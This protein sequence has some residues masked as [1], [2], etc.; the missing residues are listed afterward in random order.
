[1]FK[2]ATKQ[3]T[4]FNTHTS[5]AYS[6]SGWPLAACLSIGLRTFPPPAHL[7]LHALAI[8]ISE[9]VAVPGAEPAAA[10]TE[11]ERRRSSS[12][13]RPTGR[14]VA[15]RGLTVVSGC[16][17]PIGVVVLVSFSLSLISIGRP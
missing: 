6:C 1:V 4:Q 7:L 2:I 5:A 15:C 10:A 11:A 12:R 9:A 3:Q 8:F 17:T 14:A 16:T 13:Y